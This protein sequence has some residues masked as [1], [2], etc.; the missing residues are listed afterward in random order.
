[1]VPMYGHDFSYMP[2]DLGTVVDY[3]GL[4]QFGLDRIVNN[5][6]PFTKSAVFY[7]ADWTGIEH[8]PYCL[9]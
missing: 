6:V 4:K 3:Q 1:M 8:L 2:D 7:Q 9:T 5:L